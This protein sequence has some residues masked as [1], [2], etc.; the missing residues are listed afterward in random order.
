[1]FGIHVS[2]IAYLFKFLIPYRSVAL[3][4]GAAL[5][6]ILLCAGLVYVPFQKRL[7]RFVMP[8]NFRGEVVVVKRFAIEPLHR[9]DL[10]AFQIKSMSTTGIRVGNGFA[11][12]PILA[13][14]GDIVRFDKNN[15][16]VN[17]EIFPRLDHMPVSGEKV[18]AEKQWF[19]W[20]SFGI[21]VAGQRVAASEITRVFEANAFVTQQTLIG[22]PFSRW[23]WRKQLN[24]EPLPK[25]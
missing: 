11:I 16:A 7:A 5:S 13:G 15:F 4:V 23:F 19:V 20:P 21:N 12:E 8:M 1:M 25:S 9:G 6:V 10:V 2:S 14:P 22:K 3:R 17:G 24:Y 18:V